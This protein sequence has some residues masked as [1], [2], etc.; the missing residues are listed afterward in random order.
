MTN[1]I[2]K[3]ETYGSQKKWATYSTY[4]HEASNNKEELIKV[5]EHLNAIADITENKDKDKE[6]FYQVVSLKE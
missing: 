1:L 4:N 6:I 3:K 2:I 5:C